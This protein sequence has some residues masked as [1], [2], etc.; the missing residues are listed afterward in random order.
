[1]EQSEGFYPIG[2]KS[3]RF[4]NVTDLIT[5]V[6]HTGIVQGGN[7]HICI[8][9]SRSST[10]GLFPNALPVR[11][12]DILLKRSPRTWQHDRS[13]IMNNVILPFLMS[14]L[15]GRTID[16][17]TYTISGT[18]V[19][20][21]ADYDEIPVNSLNTTYNVIQGDV[22]PYTF[23]GIPADIVLRVK[24]NFLSSSS[25]T[26][27][28]DGIL[29][30]TSWKYNSAIVSVTTVYRTVDRM[31][32][33][34]ATALEDWSKKVPQAQTHYADSLFYGGWAVVLFRFRC[35]IPS[36]VLKVKDVL[37]KHLGVVGPLAE[38]T[39]A[40]WNDAIE[41]IRADD[42]IR[43]SV[44]LYTHVYSSVTLSEIDSPTSL[45]K[46]I[47]KLKE[48]VG[49]LGQPLFMNLEPLH[50]LDK[51]YPEVHENIEM[52]SELEK[53]DE[54]YDDVKVTVVSMRRW[55]AETLTDFDDDQEQK[56]S[57]FLQFKD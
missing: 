26:M 30:D 2:Q 51:K 47:D 55:M 19:Y 54:M 46:A 41:E 38:D 57:A 48:A 29:K 32:R 12:C 39:L 18:N 17:T 14:M 27:G 8:I 52:L 31:I 4:L 3:S 23:F 33:K 34:N 11:F 37:T 40:K 42:G 50:D 15:L 10:Y 53:L 49:S 28:L 24:S 43:G 45:L 21:D 7:R 6:T 44:N 16:L 22:F 5:L 9:F 36:D 56:V 20:D 35:D 13:P 1:M 25:G